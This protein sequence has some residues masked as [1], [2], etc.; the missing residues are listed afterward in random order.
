MAN[1]LNSKAL[2]LDNSMLIIAFLMRTWLVTLD[3]QAPVEAG[4][5]KMKKT[6]TKF[7]KRLSEAHIDM[8]L[9]IAMNGLLTEAGKSAKLSEKY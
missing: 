3:S 9:T 5:S 4:F 8:L 7:R 2:N 1:Q 6:L